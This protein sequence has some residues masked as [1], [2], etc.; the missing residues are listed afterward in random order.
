[1]GGKMTQCRCTEQHTPTGYVC[2][3]CGGM[4]YMSARERL[5]SDLT[6][7]ADNSPCSY[8]EIIDELKMQVL[9]WEKALRD[10]L[11]AQAAES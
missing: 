8:E 3:T 2:D 11:A 5:K 6:R 9:W 10:E 1:M 7:I 4:E